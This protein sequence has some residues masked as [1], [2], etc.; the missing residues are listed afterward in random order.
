M[1]TRANLDPFVQGDD[2]V[3]DL[4]F[5]D[6]KDNPINVVGDILYLTLKSN[7]DFEDA[8]AEMQVIKNIVSD[9]KAEYGLV[10]FKVTRAQSNVRAGSYHFDFQWIKNGSGS[11]EVTT[12]FLGTATVLQGVTKA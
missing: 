5:R 4:N 2:L 9:G 8:Q 3:F 11:G 6:D 12:E 7:I 1:T 10:E